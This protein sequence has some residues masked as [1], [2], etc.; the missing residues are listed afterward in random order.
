LDAGITVKVDS[1]TSGFNT[2]YIPSVYGTADQ[3]HVLIK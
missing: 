3:S 1:K 2:F